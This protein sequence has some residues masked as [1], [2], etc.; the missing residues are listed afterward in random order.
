MVST[1]RPKKDKKLRILLPHDS[2]Y[3]N[4]FSACL[5]VYVSRRLRLAA[6]SE[7][8]TVEKKP[9]KNLYTINFWF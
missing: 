4:L 6:K 7:C 2:S 5:L 8:N 3:R 9:K 1:N